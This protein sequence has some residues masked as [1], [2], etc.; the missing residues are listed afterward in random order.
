MWNAVTKPFRNIHR[1]FPTKQQAVYDLI[2]VCRKDSNIKKIVIFGSSITSACNP[3]SDI[4]VYF[5]MEKLPR[6]YP[7][8]GNPHQVFDKWC[9]FT[10]S[11]KLMT[12]I[13][14]KGVVVYG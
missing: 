14:K 3:W 1:I 4:D 6:H 8:I 10:V 2:E 9:N 11:E 5:E 12:E 13:N 7:I